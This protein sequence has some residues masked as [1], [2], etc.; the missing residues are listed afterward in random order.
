MKFAFMLIATLFAFQVQSQQ[1]EITTIDYPHDG[2]MHESVLLDVNAD[3][4]EAKKAWNSFIEDVYDVD[5]KG[6]G[7]FMKKDELQTEMVPMSFLSSEDLILNTH[8][9][10]GAKGT[11]IVVFASDA[12]GSPLNKNQDSQITENLEHLT[13][14]YVSYFLPNYHEEKVDMMSGEYE[15][16]IKDI[17]DKEDDIRKKAEDIEE[18]QEEIKTLEKEIVAANH[19]REEVK[20]KL[21]R[22]RSI[23]EKVKQSTSSL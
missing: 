20:E 5:I 3:K 13:E 7:F 14:E 15:A 10:S 9:K 12:N 22:S 18:L 16:I 19:D 4:E 2:S 8:F 21:E 17:A 11:E 6:Y 23:L 1:F